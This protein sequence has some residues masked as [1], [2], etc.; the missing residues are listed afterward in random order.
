MLDLFLPL[1]LCL[2]HRVLVSASR[3]EPE[4]FPVK[5]H[6]HAHRHERLGYLS[7][8]VTE[9]GECTKGMPRPLLFDRGLADGNPG[10][11]ADSFFR[12]DSNGNERLEVEELPNLLRQLGASN[13]D[14]SHAE[15]FLNGLERNNDGALD[16]DEFLAW[17]TRV[18]DGNSVDIGSSDTSY[19]LPKGERMGLLLIEGQEKFRKNYGPEMIGKM[20]ELANAFEERG[21]PVFR[22]SF[23]SRGDSSWSQQRGYH[24]FPWYKSSTSRESRM[25]VLKGSQ[26]EKFRLLKEITP[27]TK[28][29]LHHTWISYH[30]SMF[31]GVALHRELQ[32]EGV[33]ILVLAGGYPGACVDATAYHSWSLGYSREPE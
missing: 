18:I 6:T 13:P 5:C 28:A 12:S 19:G 25:N 24:G 22:R 14:Q 30:F 1:C 20:Q 10:N 27:K 32:E 33:G 23:Y 9:K 4:K 2:S 7:A 8:E 15:V 26:A 11:I 29:A 21:L 3:V 17:Y 31:P 16:K